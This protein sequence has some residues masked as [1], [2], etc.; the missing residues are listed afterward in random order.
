MHFDA[1]E[2]GV[3]DGAVGEI[4]HVHRAA[5]FA[6]DA[7]QQVAVEGGG[8]AG[9]IIIGGLQRG[10][11]LAGARCQIEADHQPAFRPEQAGKAAQQIDGRAGGQVADGGAGEEP[12]LRQRGHKRRQRKTAGEIGDHRQ[13]WQF[14]KLQGQGGS[15]LV[16]KFAG[17]VHRHIG[18]RIQWPQQQRSFRR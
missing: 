10:H 11:A 1:A 3:P 13:D 7:V 2:I 17:N 6:V 14:G 4:V 5:Q 9:G 12:Q 15:R 8:N 16:Q 18:R